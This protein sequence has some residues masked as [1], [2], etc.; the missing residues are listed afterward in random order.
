MKLI[1]DQNGTLTSEVVATEEFTT[2][3][4]PRIT[5]KATVK[6]NLDANSLTFE[7]RDLSR[8]SKLMGSYTVN[9]TGLECK[10]GEYGAGRGCLMCP[11]K[12]TSPPQADSINHCIF[13]NCS[14]G[15]YG[16]KD[17]CTRCPA[18]TVSTMYTIFE[19]NCTHTLVDISSSDEYLVRVFSVVGSI[20]VIL[21]ICIIALMIYRG[22]ARSKEISEGIN[23]TERQHHD[24][25]YRSSKCYE[26]HETT[27]L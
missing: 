18:G 19:A 7:V 26:N 14:K 17:N 10:D 2:V 21:V 12:G 24:A 20:F 8:G 15:Y 4:P 25:Y 1:D 11:N 5:F 16:I 9:R 23:F 3:V 27:E 22:S 6:G 13:S